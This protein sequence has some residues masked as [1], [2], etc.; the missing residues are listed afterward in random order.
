MSE[1]IRF[2][3][4][5]RHP[6]AIYHSSNTWM[7]VCVALCFLPCIT[8]LFWCRFNRILNGSLTTQYHSISGHEPGELGRQS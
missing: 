6:H 4:L 8:E 2:L 3:G 5:N 1:S 7:K